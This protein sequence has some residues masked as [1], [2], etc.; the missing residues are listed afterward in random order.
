M[1]YT[2]YLSSRS[3]A[4]NVFGQALQGPFRIHYQTESDYIDAQYYYPSLVAKWSSF[5]NDNYLAPEDN[6]RDF[7]RSITLPSA[8]INGNTVRHESDDFSS[9]GVIYSPS[10]GY[11]KVRLAAEDKITLSIYHSTESSATYFPQDFILKTSLTT[12]DNYNTASKD[13][14]NSYNGNSLEFEFI[15]HKGEYLYL[16]IN[17]VNFGSNNLYEQNPHAFAYTFSYPVFDLPAREDITFLFDTTPII[18]DYDSPNLIRNSISFSIST[19]SDSAIVNNIIIYRRIVTPNNK[20]I[21]ESSVYTSTQWGSKAYPNMGPWK[22]TRFLNNLSLVDGVPV[23]LV[24]KNKS[25][26]NS[27]N[28]DINKFTYDHEYVEVYYR[29]SLRNESRTIVYDIDTQ[30]KRIYEL[31]RIYKFDYKFLNGNYIFNWY[32]VNGTVKSLIGKSKSDPNDQ[33]IYFDNQS[34]S[35]SSTYTIPSS[36]IKNPGSYK[37][38]VSNAHGIK[39]TIS[40]LESSL[41]YNPD[42][43][44]VS[45]IAD[46]VSLPQIN[47]AP[48]YSIGQKTVKA[49]ITLPGK[50]TITVPQNCVKAT[51][52]MWGAGGKDGNVPPGY[53]RQNWFAQGGSGGHGVCDIIVCPGDTI[54]VY[55][56]KSGEGT[57]RNK[58][59][60]QYTSNRGGGWSGIIY[61]QQ[62]LI[63]GGGGAG[64]D[65]FYDPINNQYYGGGNGG[66]G[67]AAF[68][69]G[70]AG[71]QPFNKFNTI[72]TLTGTN[73]DNS[74]LIGKG[75]MGYVDVVRPDVSTYSTIRNL[76]LTTFLDLIDATEFLIP[77]RISNVQTEEDNENSSA[78][79]SAFNTSNF[80]VTPDF[81]LTAEN[82]SPDSVYWIDLKYTS[83]DSYAAVGGFYR[84]V[85]NGSEILD[86]NNG[87]CSVSETVGWRGTVAQTIVQPLDPN[88]GGGGGGG[89]YGG[90]GALMGG[91]GGGGGNLYN[92]ITFYTA[93]KQ[94]SS[95][96]TQSITMFHGIPK[97]SGA[98]S[99]I[100]L[101]VN[102]SN[103]STNANQ[104]IL[105][106]YNTEASTGTYSLKSN[107]LLDGTNI[108]N[109]RYS[110]YRTT[111]TT[112]E[113][114]YDPNG[115]TAAE[116]PI[117]GSSL[118]T[119]DPD[120]VAGT[121][122]NNQDGAVVITFYTFS[123]TEEKFVFTE[124]T[125]FEIPA[126]R[127]FRML[128]AGGAGGAGTGDPATVNNKSYKPYF[129]SIK[130]DSSLGV[131]GLGGFGNAIWSI[132]KNTKQTPKTLILQIGKCGQDGKDATNGIA[133]G[134]ASSFS[135]GGNGGKVENEGVIVG[136]VG[137]GGGGATAIYEK[138]SSYSFKGIKNF[139]VLSYG[140]Y[141][142]PFNP[143]IDEYNTT[144]TQQTQ[145]RGLTGFGGVGTEATFDLKLKSRE[146]LRY[147]FGYSRSN[148]QNII[149]DVGYDYNDYT[150]DILESTSTS[151][152][153]YIAVG[154]PRYNEVRIYRN[155]INST[156]LMFTITPPVTDTDT[157]YFGRSI[158]FSGEHAV[159]SSRFIPF[160]A[161]GSLSTDSRP[162]IYIYQFS[163][164]NVTQNRTYTGVS[165]AT[166]LNGR[167]YT[168]NWSP[169]FTLQSVISPPQGTWDQEKDGYFGYT[170]KLAYFK[171]PVAPVGTAST[172]I[173]N[174]RL[175]YV[176]CPGYNNSTGIV[177]VYKI[178]GEITSP[179]V[180]GTAPYYNHPNFTLS[181]SGYSVSFDNSL[182]S[183]QFSASTSFTTCSGCF[184]CS[185]FTQDYINSNSNVFTVN[186]GSISGIA[187]NSYFGYSIANGDRQTSRSGTYGEG[188]YVYISAP[189]ENMASGKVY[190]YDISFEYGV[191][192]QNSITTNIILNEAT[193]NLHN[194]DS[195]TGWNS[196]TKT[197]SIGNAYS[198]YTLQHFNTF[199]NPNPSDIDYFGSKLLAFKNSPYFYVTASGED[200]LQSDNNGKTYRYNSATATAPSKTINDAGRLVL[201]EEFNVS[202]VS[203]VESGRN[204]EINDILYFDLETLGFT[205][206]TDTLINPL[207]S[208]V[209]T[210][211]ETTV[212][213][214]SYC[215]IQVTEVATDLTPSPVCISAGGGGGGGGVKDLPLS[216]DSYHSAQSRNIVYPYISKY[217]EKALSLDG[218]D[219]ST[220]TSYYTS[221]GLNRNLVGYRTYSISGRIYYD[222]NKP[223]SGPGGYPSSGGGGGGGGCPPGGSKIINPRISSPGGDVL[224]SVSSTIDE[225]SYNGIKVSH[226]PFYGAADEYYSQGIFGTDNSI[227]NVMS[228][229]TLSYFRSYFD[230]KNSLTLAPPSKNGWVQDSL[231]GDVNT[232]GIA[233]GPGFSVIGTGVVNNT[234]VT[235]GITS[236]SEVYL[237][238]FLA[239]FPNSELVLSNNYQPYKVPKNGFV[240]IELLPQFNILH[241]LSTGNWAVTTNIFVFVNGWRKVTDAFI[242]SNGAW[243]KLN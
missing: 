211:L 140:Y 45:E 193:D 230:T 90:F 242:Y 22:A 204:Y 133:L 144:N 214:P 103:I 199:N 83:V 7:S 189:G 44:T 102:A 112:T 87:G 34:L 88:L 228:Q 100:S 84:R 78:T 27:F 240:Y 46:F 129:I 37:L 208:T 128:T 134:G 97:I 19:Q 226:S 194:G 99:F 143:F 160:I 215:T 158:S 66:D 29:I 186:I 6:I 174:Q 233:G 65:Y 108:F 85:A 121:G 239:G 36:S 157:E 171:D 71:S 217:Y 41:K 195:Y 33:T 24:T 48:N 152:T 14:G 175:L 227:L 3:Q 203:V 58:I 106:N 223:S 177:Y 77:K 54:D 192:Q 116:N 32:V 30:R 235:S 120:Y 190:V 168:F 23:G 43:I 200:V 63:V 212:V 72:E 61:G 209:N 13:S 111:N 178:A 220:S 127:R 123:E 68:S 18:N 231:L 80:Y 82:N 76:P 105:S 124:D 92:Y 132:Y 11:H 142:K 50:T 173:R 135:S 115:P 4:G 182:S 69:S 35:N 42:D 181:P 62:H 145:I 126:R 191:S 155:S 114:G 118:G 196:T 213:V 73:N 229:M 166:Y 17:T 86:L 28:D 154:L 47:P 60:G 95:S 125:E 56:G 187:E 107:S 243:R 51:V 198:R 101:V 188:R 167:S 130:N 163:T 64:G 236:T 52:K 170:I 74:L 153:D 16:V 238:P 156:N 55:V 8:Y 89:Y 31:P 136:G 9:W 241:R 165:N 184:N 202:E 25:F 10:S 162:K 38:V 20:L 39:S 149:Q 57:G 159:L 12:G 218:I 117:W 210:S 161:I 49:I 197:A 110:R 150:I 53:V 131:G 206:I 216:I 224:T 93:Q 79:T 180:T 164:A 98:D 221:F 234:L 237:P 179:I 2:R 151:G 172:N 201:I 91:G 59:T 183:T 15:A 219:A 5:M 113:S 225:Y 94:A 205:N 232:P 40:P 26:S 122:G 81:S 146:V 104:T 138:E 185:I 109:A 141:V 70:N 147:A 169:Y 75:G 148:Y 139:N 137:G 119:Y 96:S 222:V 207:D 67:V 21:E 176:G 1:Q